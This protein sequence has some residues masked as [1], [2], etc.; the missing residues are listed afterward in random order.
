MDKKRKRKRRKEQDKKNLE[1]VGGIATRM[2]S[3]ISVGG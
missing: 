3:K 2:K 1:E